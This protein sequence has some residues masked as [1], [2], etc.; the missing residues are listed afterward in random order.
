MLKMFVFYWY[1]I[2]KTRYSKMVKNKDMQLFMEHLKMNRKRKKIF[3]YRDLN[4]RF[5]IIFPPM[6][7]IFIE[8]EGDEIKSKQASKID[9]TLSPNFR[10]DILTYQCQIKLEFRFIIDIDLEV[11]LWSLLDSSCFFILIFLS[12][13]QIKLFV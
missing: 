12:K 10:V 1:L 4:P 13:E 8:G 2:C 6:T 11:K 7:W 9:M 3:W 5:P